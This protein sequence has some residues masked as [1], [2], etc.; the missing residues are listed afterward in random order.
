MKRSFVYT[1]LLAMLL[2]AAGMTACSKHDTANDTGAP[3]A[4]S[5]DSSTNTASAPT[6]APA[7]GA[8][9]SS[10][11]SNTPP[12]GADTSASAAP[13]AATDSAAAN[14]SGSTMD[15]ATLTT[16]V[17]TALATDAGLRTLK[18]NVDS[19]SGTVTINGDVTSQ[20]QHDAVTKVAQGVTG[21]TTVQN[22]TTVKAK[23]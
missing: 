21:V 17:K 12:S 8:T 15:N 10:T 2:G 23:G 1:G 20:E 5:N 19:S 18:L 13:A 22:N 6:P 11:A 16:K 14:S 3:P 4:A 9:D 7:P